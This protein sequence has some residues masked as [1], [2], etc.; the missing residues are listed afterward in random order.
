MCVYSMVVDHFQEKWEP[1]RYWPVEAIS[2][3][4]SE[5]VEFRQLLER[6]RKY[7]EAHNE[8]DCEL[9][10]KKEKLLRL[11]EELGVLAGVAEAVAKATGEARNE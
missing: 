6:A 10:E 4:P 7:D 11:A 3:R 1:R 8:P 5:L 2:I 9:A